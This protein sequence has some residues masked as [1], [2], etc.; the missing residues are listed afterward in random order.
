[1]SSELGLLCHYE[2]IP[3]AREI[4]KIEAIRH[5]GIL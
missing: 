5:E 3:S 4:H 1:M 2:I